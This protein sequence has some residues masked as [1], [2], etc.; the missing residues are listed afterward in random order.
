MTQSTVSQQ[1]T[2]SFDNTSPSASSTPC[3]KEVKGRWVSFQVVR[4]GAE[5]VGD[6]EIKEVPASRGN[7][8]GGFKFTQPIKVDVTVKG[9]VVCT[10][11]DDGRTLGSKEV[12]KSLPPLKFPLSYT[13]AGKIPLLG[14]L[15][16]AKDLQSIDRTINSAGNDP[17]AADKLNDF[18]GGDF[19]KR[20]K[21]VKDSADNICKSMNK[22]A[23]D[24]GTPTS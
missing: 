1:L 19:A 9:K 21:E 23:G 24:S 20:L 5:R 13:L 7:I 16:V 3:C 4:G 8:T 2:Q 14:L 12:E 6:F 11:A 17:A 18:S 22:C 15:Y 10:C